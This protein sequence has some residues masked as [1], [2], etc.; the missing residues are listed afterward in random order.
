MPLFVALFGPARVDHHQQ[1]AA[2]C[3]CLPDLFDDVARGQPVDVEVRF[4]INRP[5]P[6]DLLLE[7]TSSHCGHDR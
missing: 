2:P 6:A 5:G 3:D 7:R 1:S 4:A